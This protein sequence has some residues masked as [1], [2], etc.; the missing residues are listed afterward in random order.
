MLMC[1]YHCCNFCVYLQNVTEDPLLSAA[2]ILDSTVLWPSLF[3]LN[4]VLHILWPRLSLKLTQASFKHPSQGYLSAVSAVIILSHFGEMSWYT[5]WRILVKCRD[6][7]IFPGKK[8]RSQEPKTIMQACC[9]VDGW[10]FTLRTIWLK[11]AGS[12]LGTRQTLKHYLI[13]KRWTPLLMIWIYIKKTPSKARW[14]LEWV[15]YRDEDTLTTTL[16]RRQ[17][18]ALLCF[19]IP[20]KDQVWNKGG[21]DIKPFHS[22]SA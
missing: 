18:T 1:V 10:I 12:G 8:L 5:L 22:F 16:S 17:R 20:V 19:G 14:W 21:V 7:R 11:D 13:R 4:I 15:N 6:L 9:Y 2:N 3:S